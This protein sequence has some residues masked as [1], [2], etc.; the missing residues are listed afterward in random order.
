MTLKKEIEEDI[1]KWRYIPCSWLGRT[2][3]ITLSLLPKAI[4]R[5]NAIYV[6]M[7]MTYFTKLEQIFQKLMEP[8]K[9]PNSILKES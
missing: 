4:Y 7:P 8:Q 3:V 6:K 2:D 9:I 1:K 5:S